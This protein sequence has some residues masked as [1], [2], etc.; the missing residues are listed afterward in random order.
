MIIRRHSLVISVAL[1]S[2]WRNQEVKTANRCGHL[3][4]SSIYDL[5]EDSFFLRLAKI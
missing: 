5:G 4:D 3:S 2:T 1:L